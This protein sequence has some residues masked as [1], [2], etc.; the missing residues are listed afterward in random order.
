MF[1]IRSNFG[2]VPGQSPVWTAK[3]VA[4]WMSARNP[5]RVY[6][7]VAPTGETLTAFKRGYEV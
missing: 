6:A 1:E 4:R 5:G 2:K 7:I 3:R